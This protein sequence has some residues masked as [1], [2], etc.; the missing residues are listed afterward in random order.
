MRKISRKSLIYNQSLFAGTKIKLE[1]LD[2]RRPGTGIL[3]NKISKI[4]GKI[5]KRT[6]DGSICK[7]FRFFL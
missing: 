4:K 6:V 2:C 5:L 1:D 3:P 7:I